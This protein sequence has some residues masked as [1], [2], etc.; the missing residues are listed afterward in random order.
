MKTSRKLSPGGSG[1][2]KK[3]LTLGD[4]IASTYNAC[5]DRAPRLLQLALAAQLI[6]LRYGL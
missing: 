3:T 1:P 2:T 4:L 5:G 6:R